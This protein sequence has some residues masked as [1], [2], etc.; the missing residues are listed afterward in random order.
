MITR[1]E[2]KIC[3]YFDHNTITTIQEIDSI[4]NFLLQVSLY[5]INMCKVWKINA[6]HV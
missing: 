3:T 5:F 6:W 2:M 1:N 4:D